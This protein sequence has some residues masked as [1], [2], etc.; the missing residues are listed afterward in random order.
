MGIK[1]ETNQLKEQGGGNTKMVENIK[2]RCA[3]HKF[4]EKYIKGTDKSNLEE[5]GT[6]KENKKVVPT[7]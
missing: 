7:K 5:M 4:S 6:T 1:K 3:L 2:Y